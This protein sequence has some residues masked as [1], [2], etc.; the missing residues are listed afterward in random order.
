MKNWKISLLSLACAMAL[1]A[2][3]GGG[4]SDDPNPPT[5]PVPPTPS[6]VVVDGSSAENFSNSLSCYNPGAAADNICNLRVYQVMVE[7]FQD[8]DPNIGY[9]VGYGTSNHNGDLEGIINSLDYIKSIGMNAIWLTPIFTSCDTSNCSQL[10]ATGYYAKD[11]FS[12]DSHFGTAEK[13]KELVDTAHSKGLYVFLDGVFGHF[14][15][16]VITTS[17][18]NN[19][20]KTTTTCLSD[21]GT[22]N[23]GD[24]ARCADYTDPG[25]LEFFKEVATYYITEYKIDGWRLD[26]AYQVPLAS[27]TAIRESVENASQNTTYLNANNETVN[28][29]GYMV[30]EIWSSNEK[31]QSLGFGSNDSIGMN[32]LFAF[33]L[34]YALVQ[35]LAVEE[36]GNAQHT[37]TRLLQGL[38]AD[39]SSFAS[40]A[41]PN[42]M[43]TNHDLV[44]FGDLIQRAKKLN[45]L[46]A[47]DYY[48]R[49]KLAQSFLTAYSGPITNYYNEEEG[50]EVKNFDIKVTTNCANAGLCDDHVSRD[51]GHID[52][53]DFNAEQLDSKAYFTKLMK[54]RAAHPALF[55]GSLKPLLVNDDL[56]VASKTNHDDVVYMFMNLGTNQDYDVQFSS[57]VFGDISNLTD[58][59]TCTHYSSN[60]TS[61]DF[62]LNKLS[63]IFLVPND[64]Q[65]EAVCITDNE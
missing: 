41:K 30:G 58:P 61:A 32:S 59:I 21:S 52:D 14:R 24:N 35:A 53:P 15:N 12:I 3:G 17:P 39:N 48:A 44:R 47:E 57:A 29:L 55:N 4:G 38:T 6:A 64:E 56:F 1:T 33:N 20:L 60:G 54:F 34:R 5:P 50:Q 2:C 16:D 43:I 27:W 10:D 26:Q 9:G 18:N 45:K 31:I 28:P 62:K 65:S 63:V 42:L 46:A 49:V 25:T 51:N 7:A 8:G 36:S 13:L 19:Q 37:G 22:Y 11:F 40:H 23:S